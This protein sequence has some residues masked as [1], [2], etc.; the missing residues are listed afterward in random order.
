M[1]VVHVNTDIGDA[2]SEH[3]AHPLPPPSPSLFNLPERKQES[4]HPWHL[5]A[6][7]K[8]IIGVPAGIWCNAP[9][10]SPIT[11]IAG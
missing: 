8:L 6:K 1:S 3:R 4:V 2:G 11:L 7:G 9:P 10:S 5:N